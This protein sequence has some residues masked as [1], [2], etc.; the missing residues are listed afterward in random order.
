MKNALGQ[1]IGEYDYRIAPMGA[2]GFVTGFDISADGQRLV[3][4][5]DVFNGYI[6][7]AGEP[8]WQ[9]AFRTDTLQTVEY[10][11]LPANP[12]PLAGGRAMY[13]MAIAP[14]NKD[15]IYADY[16]GYVYKSTDGGGEFLRTAAAQAHT[17]PGS[18]PARRFN[19]T[20]SVHPTDPNIVIRGTNNSGVVY[21]TNGGTSW[22]AVSGLAAIGLCRTDGNTDDTLIGKHLT[23]F[24]P[25]QPNTV[26]IHVFGTGLYRSTTGVS[27]T[28]TLLG[29]SPARVSC[30]MVTPTG[31]VY[32]CQFRETAL[33]TD[34]IKTMTRAG[35]WGAITG[36]VG[37]DQVAVNPNDPLHIV[38]TGENGG[39]NQ[40]RDGGSTYT[41]NGLY[42]GDGET[43]WFSNRSKQ[44]FPAKFQFDPVV[45]EKIWISEGIGICYA[46]CPATTEVCTVHDYS[47]GNEELIVTLFMKKPGNPVPLI[48]A[49]DKPIWRIEDTRRP[50]NRFSFP[51]NSTTNVPF[52]EAGVT[53]GH[54]IDWAIDDDD[55]LAVACGQG[56]TR[57]GYSEDFGRTWTKYSGEP[58]GGWTGTGGCVA[59]SNRDNIIHLMSNNGA[60]YYTLDGGATWT[61]IVLGAESPTVSWANAYYVTRQNVT[62]DKERP[63]VF[64]VVVNN[65]IPFSASE[66]GRANSGCWVT[67]NGGVSWT[68]KYA[69]V[70]GGSV[71][72][73]STTQ[74]WQGKLS[75]IPGRSGELLW[76]DCEGNNN[77]LMWSQDDGAT[78]TDVRSDVRRLSWYGFGKA[79]EG[80]TRPA[81][82]FI[83]MVGSVDSPYV[84][85]VYGIY[86][87]Y[88][89]FATAPQLITR[90]PNNIVATGDKIEGDMDTFGRHYVG[91][92]GNGGLVCD[93]GKRFTL[94]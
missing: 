25:G 45:D 87:S 15:V 92:G 55:F 38:W 88:D 22:T 68:R 26:Y 84:A 2:G 71:P 32:M 94:T 73:S 67:T 11:P 4:W 80:Q 12:N 37:A 41:D 10:D 50:T 63:G 54:S 16:N 47:A 5:T 65:I 28:F 27:G 31:V 91:I 85:G 1:Y 82:Y 43:K 89:W 86:V 7:N 61:A 62:A 13:A 78:W 81:V 83:G 59:V 29:S 39:F 36:S 70:I 46:Q 76:A 60:G 18:G 24:D 53:I 69:G 33:I 8:I 21:S 42:R 20:L 77:P 49:W 6:R 3:H 48:V 72:F 30:L 14:S 79:K 75:Y 66:L 44:L 52:P 51:P 17:L 74:F 64:A 40:T 35:A 90:F 9:Q 58:S 57:L 19:H 34:G 56:D 93:Y 23:A